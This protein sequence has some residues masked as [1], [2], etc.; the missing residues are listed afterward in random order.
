MA[1]NAGAHDVGLYSAVFR[2]RA[3]ARTV[4][5]SYGSM[6][7]HVEVQRPLAPTQVR[8]VS[9]RNDNERYRVR[10]T[11]ARSAAQV[12]IV[13]REGVITASAIASRA[14]E[15][16][17]EFVVSRARATA[18]GA[19]FRAPLRDRS[20]VGPQL[21]GRFS[22]AREGEG[23]RV[24]LTVGNPA[25]AAP[26][27]WQVGGRQRGPRDNRFRF[28]VSRDGVALPARDGLDFGGP[29]GFVTIAPGESTTVSAA[30]DRWADASAP[31]HYCVECAYDTTL[32]ADGVAPF[33]PE[34]QHRVWD[35]TFEGALEFD[36]R[37]ER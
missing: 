34:Q 30:L 19:L 5:A 3:S 10:A 22:I 16:E 21:E 7:V 9:E 1:T 27:Q 4:E 29:T 2:E 6:I 32:A 15:T 31:G 11:I 14:G 13:L 24:S 23:M 37:P 17:V 18:I 35:R 20:V 25:G 33:E 26:V 12:V 36:V 8:L 28:R